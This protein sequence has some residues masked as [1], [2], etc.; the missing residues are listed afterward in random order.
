M[1]IEIEGGY[2]YLSDQK[3]EMTGKQMFYASVL[4]DTAKDEIRGKLTLRNIGGSDKILFSI[5][6]ALFNESSINQ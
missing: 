6:G 2:F 5:A 3:D 1:G 4:N